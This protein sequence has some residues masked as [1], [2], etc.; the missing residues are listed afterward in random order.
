MMAGDT[1]S[2]ASLDAPLD[3]GE[4]EVGSLLGG[5]DPEVAIASDWNTIQ[6]VLDRLPERER[7]IVYLRFFEDLTQ[8]EIAGMV[9][10]SQVH[11]SRLLDKSLRTIRELLAE[12]EPAP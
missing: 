9:G 1:Y 3:D 10:V 11:V 2:L 6:T 12:P 7:Q 4:R 8:S 5:E